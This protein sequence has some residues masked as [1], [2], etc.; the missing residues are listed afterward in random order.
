MA[1]RRLDDLL[2]ERGLCPDRDQAMRRVMAGEVLVD[3]RAAV[4][5]GALVDP[6]TEL[7]LSTRPPYVS[8]GGLKLDAAL[9]AYD[10]LL[11]GKVVADVGA[12]T[13]GFTDCALQQGARR[14][15]AIDV[16]TGA[17]AWSLRT[18]P[19]VVVMEGVNAMHLCELPE[20]V[21]VITLDLSFTSLRLV[22]PQVLRWLVP[23]GAVIALIKPQY[24]ASSSAQLVGGVVVDPLERRQIVGRLL[25]W[26]QERGWRIEGLIAS[27]IQ[28]SGGNWEYL[29]HLCRGDMDPSPTAAKVE[30][31]VA[32]VI[33]V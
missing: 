32:T 7:R 9:R 8:R 10:L 29:A 20:Q 15:Y 31:R 24:E 12:S 13:G 4:T 6:D 22:L 18:D 16:A 33:P 1:R 17:L 23:G 25:C 19:R 3:G 26:V 30:T 2:V 5:S 21:D 28:G 11:T 27:P 14:V